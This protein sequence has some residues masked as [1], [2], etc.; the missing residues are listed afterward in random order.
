MG[1]GTALKPINGHTT[2]IGPAFHVVPYEPQH[3]RAMAI[4]PAQAH[5]LPLL[6]GDYPEKAKLGGPA[7][8][9]LQHG[10]P[11]ACAGFHEHWEGRSSAWAI[12]GDPGADMLRVTRAVLDA[13]AGHPAERIEAYVRVGFA[14]G[15]RWARLLGFHREGRMGRF[16]KGQD[17]WCYVLFKDT[18]LC[19]K[20]QIR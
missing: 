13:L 11:V 12:L 5:L 20:R 3:L 15:E 16:N 8:T 18:L 7:W 17:Y 4:Q 9:A 19:D 14:P 2:W 10:V 1:Y 6:D